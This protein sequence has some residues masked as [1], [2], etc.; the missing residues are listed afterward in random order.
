MFRLKTGDYIKGIAR[1]KHDKDKFAP[2]IF[3]SDVNGIKPGEAFNRLSFED[4]TPIYPNQRIRLETTKENIFRVHSLADSNFK[5]HH[6]YK[7]AGA[8]QHGPSVGS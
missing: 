5:F 3:V 7:N 2:L 8:H 6:A 4:L 1:E